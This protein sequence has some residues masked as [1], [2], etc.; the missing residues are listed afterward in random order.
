MR[1]QLQTIFTPS[2]KDAHEL[3]GYLLTIRERVRVV[4]LTSGVRYSNMMCT[5]SHTEAQSEEVLL[6]GAVAE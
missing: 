3:E 4:T 5:V 2:P 6:I 1:R